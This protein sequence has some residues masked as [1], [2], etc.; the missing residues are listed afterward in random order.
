[1][2]QLLWGCFS[3][4][5]TTNVNLMLMLTKGLKPIVCVQTCRNT[6]ESE[7]LI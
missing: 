5:H 7:C 2:E 3:E 4:G 6:K 1:M